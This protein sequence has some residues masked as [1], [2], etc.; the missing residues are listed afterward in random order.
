MVVLT[1]SLRE[2][3]ADELRRMGA[4]AVLLKG[5]SMREL[6]TTLATVVADRNGSRL[7]GE[8][9]AQAALSR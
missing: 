2:G 4:A 7:G 8:A 9:Q 1:S 5:C 3:E 6:L